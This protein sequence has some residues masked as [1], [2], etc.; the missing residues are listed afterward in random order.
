M[1]VRMS[2]DGRPH[3]FREGPSPDGVM[4]PDLTPYPMPESLPQPAKS[5]RSRDP[6]LTAIVVILFIVTVVTMIGSFL[7]VGSSMFEPGFRVLM[8]FTAFALLVL[9]VLGS[10]S[11]DGGYPNRWLKGWP[12]MLIIS[13]VLVVWGVGYEFFMFYLFG[14]AIAA[15]LLIWYSSRHPIEVRDHL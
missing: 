8:L 11:L 14:L 15:Q 13:L 5:W 9:C 4:D 10:Q 12:L 3:I 7:I 6:V 1:V 2:G